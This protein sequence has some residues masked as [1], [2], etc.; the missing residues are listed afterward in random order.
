MTQPPPVMVTWTAEKGWEM[1]VL[2]VK[3]ARIADMLERFGVNTFSSTASD[4]NVWGSWP[5]DYSPTSVTA[6]LK[7]LVGASG[8]TIRVREY[9]YA[10]QRS[11]QEPWCQTIHAATGAPFSV[12]IGAG[13]GVADATSIVAM[14]TASAAGTKWLTQV[15]GINEPNNNFGSG[16][17]PVDAVIAAQTM[18]SSGIAAISNPPQVASPSIVFG[19]P[20]PEGYIMPGYATAAQ[21][22]TIN[23]SCSFGNGHMYPPDEV[24]L[25][26]GSGRG[27]TMRDVVVGLNQVYG[28]PL[29]VT[30]W[31]PTL[32][33]SH[34]VNLNPAVDAYYAP[35]FF[36]SAFREGIDAWYWF[37][38]LDY[39]T[40]Y[41][42][43]LFPKT[44]A[45]APRPVA[46]TIRAMF[47]LTGDTGLTKHTFEPGY[48]DYTVAG[49][50]SGLTPNSGGQHM[51]FQNS[52]GTFFLFVW[53]AQSLVDGP[54]TPVTVKFGKPHRV[55]VYKISDVTTPTAVKQDL[56]NASSVSLALGGAVY[57]LVIT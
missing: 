16:T 18:L 53:L 4:S 25:E 9:H 55:R 1:K 21:M 48:L 54:T 12:A 57:L 17:I 37:A 10:N 24:D 49:L 29:T 30:E 38:L 19:L 3:A 11:W 40:I 13:G 45:V 32:Y 39:A 7:W 51:L 26:D 31:H 46:N 20:F 44:G 5:A 2:G 6:A 42:S 27:G 36:L 22:A 47:T 14:A 56:S 50:P 35:C 23:A 34:G 33:N 8:L 28:H 15:E 41:L 52:A 43:G